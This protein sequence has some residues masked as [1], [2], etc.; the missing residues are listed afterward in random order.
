MMDIDLNNLPTFQIYDYRFD[1]FFKKLQPNGLQ[2]DEIQRLEM[3]QMIDNNV[4]IKNSFI[5][6]IIA[7]LKELDGAESEYRTIERVI[8]NAWMFTAL[9]TAD[10]MVTCKY[11]LLANTDYDRRYMRGKLKVILNEGIKKLVGFKADKKDGRIWTS[12]SGIMKHFPGSVFQQQFAE[13][14]RRLRECIDQS[15]WWKTERD[16]ETHLD[17]IAII[18]TRQ[19]DLDENTVMLESLQL[20]GAV[21]A[22]S[23]FLQ[24]LHAAL[25]NWLNDLYKKHPEIF[26]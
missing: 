11:F 17:P 25:T 19:E 5:N 8:L 1:A 4:A 24:N 14:D 18:S 9:T 10:C 13:L 3:V 12:I 21:D 7:N 15:S 20:I 26:K 6:Y 2:L 23:H 16:A 22:V